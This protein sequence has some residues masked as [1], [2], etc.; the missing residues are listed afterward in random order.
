MRAGR[1]GGEEVSVLLATVVSAIVGAVA[2]AWATVALGARVRRRERAERLEFRV[3]ADR[4]RWEPLDEG[5]KGRFPEAVGPGALRLEYRAE[6]RN[7]GTEAATLRVWRWLV[8]DA[9]ERSYYY[10]PLESRMEL[11]R[12]GEEPAERTL[13]DGEEGDAFSVQAGSFAALR[14]EGLFVVLRGEKEGGPDGCAPRFA[15]SFRGTT[16]RRGRNHPR[17]GRP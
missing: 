2:G 5:T 3:V 10:L 15:A 12:V 4:H 14:F 7:R 16:S 17:L 9:W 1:D 8:A 6:L 13:R 11:V